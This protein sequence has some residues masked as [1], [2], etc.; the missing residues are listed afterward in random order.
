MCDKIETYK[1][2]AHGLI[3]SLYAIL[4]K[5]AKLTPAKQVDALDRGYAIDV[6]GDYDQVIL[7]LDDTWF[8]HGITYHSDSHYIELRGDH[9][10]I[11]KELVEGTTNYHELT[12]LL[13]DLISLL[14]RWAD[15]AHIEK[16]KE[17]TDGG[18]KPS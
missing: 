4:A 11:Q 14:E 3:D 16:T 8:T 5:S 12:Q 18:T 15:A 13:D 2:Q 1:K 6:K 9:F 17:S 7:T 10:L